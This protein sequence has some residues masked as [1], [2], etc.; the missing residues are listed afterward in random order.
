MSQ[1]SH[2]AYCALNCMPHRPVP[3]TQRRWF[4]GV[5]LALV[6]QASA[7]SAAFAADTAASQ[8]SAWA[9]AAKTV[10]AGYAASAERGKTFFNKQFGKSAEMA[11][12]A[13]CHTTSPAA[14]GKHSVSGKA[15][16]PLSPNTNAE[17]FA[18]ATKTEK[19]FK[20]NCN[21]VLG[22]VCTPAE[23]ADFVSFLITQR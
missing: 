5:A 7:S 11:S 4:F 18:D 21:D 19:W 1:A 16:S 15:I 22:R 13:T 3:S 9:T 23:K 10:D 20:R 17:R 12:C 14:H 2:K 6:V 8:I